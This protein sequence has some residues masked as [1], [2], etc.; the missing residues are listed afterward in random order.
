MSRAQLTSTVEQ[1]TGG[2]VSPWVGGKNFAAN[3]G[4]DWWQRGTSFSSSGVY[5][6]DRW[7][8]TYGGTV[9]ASQETS[10]IPTGATYA[11]K[12]L[13][14]ASSSFGE[15]YNALESLEVN[16]LAGQTITVSGYVRAG[17]GY[18]GSAVIAIQT[19]TT[20]NTQTGGTWTE[21]TYATQTPSTFAYT[22]FSVTYAVPAGTAGLR[23]RLGNTSTQSSGVA[24][25]WGN[26][27]IEIGS[28]ATPFSRAAGTLQ[29]E[30]AL[31]Q[32]YYEKSYDLATAPGTA[33]N[34][35]FTTTSAATTSYIYGFVPY[36]VTKRTTPTVLIWDAGGNANAT[37][38]GLLGNANSN[39]QNGAVDIQSM[40]GF[41]WLSAGSTNANIAFIHFAASA[42]L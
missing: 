17:S 30:L 36:K 25:Y 19:N 9:T 27:Q 8:F 38:R 28:I 14:G 31:C 37:T 29:G 20:A 39:N 6:A 18:T 10:I 15:L 32:R 1:N 23:I 24:L 21:Q 41:T 33:V 12:L 22:R 4:F 3:G 13:T 40:T 34:S 35:T 42:E 2:A 7:Y 11:A 16:R 26:I 5:S